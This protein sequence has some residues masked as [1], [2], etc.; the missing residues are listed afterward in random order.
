MIFFAASFLLFALLPQFA[1]ILW[2]DNAICCISYN[3]GFQQTISNVFVKEYRQ[4][5]A[6]YDNT[7]LLKES[8]LMH[9]LVKI[10]K[11]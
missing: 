9:F 3:K 4:K 1:C 5:W 6:D 2:I 8:Y 10:T 7:H 11:F